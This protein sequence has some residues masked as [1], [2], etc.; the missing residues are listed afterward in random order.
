MFGPA[1]QDMHPNV[2]ATWQREPNKLTWVENFQLQ[3]SPTTAHSVSE[4]PPVNSVRRTLSW[5]PGE[6]DGGKIL[7]DSYA[8]QLDAGAQAAFSISPTPG[9]P[10]LPL[11]QGTLLVFLVKDLETGP[12]QVQLE[13]D[14]GEMISAG[15]VT[16]TPNSDPAHYVQVEIEL[17]PDAARQ[18]KQVVLELEAGQAMVDDIRLVSP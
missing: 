10:N 2:H 17:A 5:K 15:I 14:T 8:L 1:L 3:A 9:L 12:L 4:V 13:T 7:G 11:A 18:V 6:A 16:P